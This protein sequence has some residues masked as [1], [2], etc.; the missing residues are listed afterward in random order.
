MTTERLATLMRFLDD[1]P[2]DIF[3]H[4]AIAQE[5]V[6]VGNV[7]A[8]LEKYEEIIRLDPAYVPAYHQFG[9]LLLQL[10]REDDARTMLS[11]GVV[12]AMRIGDTHAQAEMQEVLDELA[13]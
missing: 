1:D 13:T 5:H 2:T 3:A 6:S 9:L 8:A 11:R 4:Y 10:N 12:A 7:S